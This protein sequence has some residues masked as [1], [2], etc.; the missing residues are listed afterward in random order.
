MGEFSAQPILIVR[1]R[2]HSSFVLLWC[3][4][5]EWL[6]EYTYPAALAELT[7]GIQ[8]MR[9]G[10]EL[11][12]AGFSHKLCEFTTYLVDRMAE[13]PTALMTPPLSERF[14]QLKRKQV[15]D[16]RHSYYV[17]SKQ[18]NYGRLLVLQDPKWTVEEV[19]AA[20]DPVDAAMLSQWVRSLFTRLHVHA[21]AMGN[22]TASETSSLITNI[23]Q[24]LKWSPL[25][26]SERPCERVA[27]L[28]QG[29]AVYVMQRTANA[30]EGNS[31]VESYYQIG[32]DRELKAPLKIL[33]HVPEFP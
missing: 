11:Q 28:P 13:F 27:D 8:A 17:P 23:R 2:Y 29:R 1:I 3:Q 24:S 4:Q 21:L 6:A 22:I 18:A 33:E 30:K 10:I 19:V 26:A 7:Y 15:R 5:S 9:M 14:T 16:L 32:I 12:V 20:A 31:A 25:L